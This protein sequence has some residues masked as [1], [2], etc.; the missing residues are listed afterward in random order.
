MIILK[1]VQ[2]TDSCQPG[3]DRCEYLTGSGSCDI[4]GKLHEMTS[5]IKNGKEPS[6]GPTRPSIHVCPILREPGSRR[7]FFS[8]TISMIVWLLV[9]YFFCQERWPASTLTRSDR[10]FR[11]ESRLEWYPGRIQRQAT[12]PL[13]LAPALGEGIPGI[14]RAARVSRPFSRTLLIPGDGNPISDRGGVWADG[15]LFEIFDIDFLAGDRSRALTVPRALVLSESL[16]QRCFPGGGALGKTVRINGREDFEVTGIFRDLPA[17]FPLGFNFAVS[18][19][20]AA[21]AETGWASST[22][23]TYLLLEAKAAPHQVEAGIRNLLE[24]RGGV[25]HKTLYLKP[26]SRIPRDR[27]VYFEFAPI[28]GRLDLLPVMILALVIL[29]SAWLNLFT[30]SVSGGGGAE[31]SSRDESGPE[32]GLAER[33][34]EAFSIPQWFIL[35]GAPLLPA[36]PAALVLAPAFGRLLGRNPGPLSFSGWLLLAAAALLPV[37]LGGVKGASWLSF[38]RNR[39]F[40]RRSS[41]RRGSRLFQF[42]TAA[43]L[44]LLAL[45]AARRAARSGG[46][47][48]GFEPDN[49]LTMDFSHLDRDGLARAT[50]LRT[51]LLK[52]P[53]VL[54]AAFSLRLPF[55]TLGTS[56]VALDGDSTDPSIMVRINLVNADFAEAFM[57]RLTP[58]SREAARSMGLADGSWACLVNRAAAAALGATD[59][60]RGGASLIGR[61]VVFNEGNRPVVA[62]VIRDFP[63]TCRL[64]G[65]E[66]LVLVYQKGRMFAYPRLSLRIYSGDRANTLEFIEARYRLAFPD[67]VYDGALFERTCAPHFR[68]SAAWALLLALGAG[69][70][71]LLGWLGIKNGGSRGPDAAIP[72]HPRLLL[73]EVL[74]WGGGFLYAL[75]VIKPSRLYFGFGMMTPMPLF[76]TE[77]TLV[78][79]SAWAPGGTV[80]ALAGFLGQLFYRGWI[81]ALVITALAGILAWLAARLVSAVG[82]RVPRPV[83]Y[84]PSLLL[85]MC[86]GRYENPLGTALGLAAAMTAALLYSA[87]FFSRPVY[88][89]GLFAGLF[90]LVLIAAG[91][92]AFLFLAVV[93]GIEVLKRHNPIGAAAACG[94]AA[95]VPAVYGRLFFDLSAVDLY[96]PHLPFHTRFLMTSGVGLLWALVLFFPLLVFAALAGKTF[97]ARRNSVHAIENPDGRWFNRRAFSVLLVLAVSAAGLAVSRDAGRSLL[98]EMIYRSF[99]RDW[100][101]VLAQA[102]R[103]PSGS[104]NLYANYQINRALYH[105]GRLGDEMFAYTQQMDALALIPFETERFVMRDAAVIDTAL[106]LGALNIAEHLNLEIMEVVGASSPVLRS[107][108]MVNLAK[109]QPETARVYLG[110]M[111]H[112][113]IFKAEANRWLNG[114]IDAADLGRIEAL[115]AM[116]LEEDTANIEV[117]ELLT[118]LLERNPYNRMAFEYLMALFLM[119]RRLDKLI[120]NLSHLRLLGA[121]HLPRHYEEAILLHMLETGEGVDLKGW[122][123]SQESIDGYQEF[124]RL[125]SSGG[126][127][128]APAASREIRD[129]FGRSYFFYYSFNRSGVEP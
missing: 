17:S 2:I 57:L 19:D 121:E 33:R 12:S 93:V 48:M 10:I 85:F 45:G 109:Q 40:P 34:G 50:A 59:A 5:V 27:E 39:D 80:D 36:V 126:T 107:L 82:A 103:L 35:S 96:G 68:S 118:D 30:F 11:I 83:L 74:L 99:S 54:S 31:D 13:P 14:E 53:H 25:E 100:E 123:I 38:F 55:E 8:L 78:E 112:D 76:G 29:A 28:L 116:N 128:A 98:H 75:L 62:G 47:D 101:N 4:T 32:S 42:L 94:F 70:C 113:P 84:I 92:S 37:F 49:V 122:E 127:E 125:M 115:Q 124:T 9:A 105:L 3:D 87:L 52:H 16:A 119:E 22:V 111:S 77:R 21:S 102:R 120:E 71:L 56:P 67:D 106:D 72:R 41:L 66:P 46:A 90:C 1:V 79:G 24:T 108:A 65:V 26:L 63:F 61:Q 20:L 97:Q 7:I 58:A 117:G 44:I 95:L 114:D 73:P 110:A 88:R 18:S 51:E 23:F 15:D 89:W 64:D 6:A 129:K 69:A 86:F 43:I 60:E 104:Y 81:G 91:G